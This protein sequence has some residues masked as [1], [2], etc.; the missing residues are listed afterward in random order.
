MRTSLWTSFISSFALMMGSLLT[1]SCSGE[2]AGPG[3][4]IPSDAQ[5][6]PGQ[7]S[8][9]GN[10][11]NSCSDTGLFV[12]EIECAG[13]TVCDATLGCVSCSPGNNL[14][15]G[16]EVHSCNTDGTPGPLVTA[17]DFAQTCRAGACI[18]SC[19][20]AA[21]EFVYLLDSN[22]QLLSFEPRNDTAPNAVKVIGK[23]TCPTTSAPNSMSVDRRARAWLNYDDGK[24]YK[25]PTNNPTACADSG[26]KTGVVPTPKVGMG[27]VSDTAGSK[28]ESL[29][30]ASFG[31]PSQ[32]WKLNPLDAAPIVATR[33]GTFPA[34]PTSPE[35]TGTGAAELYAYFP[36]TDASHRIIRVNKTSGQAELTY[37]LPPLASSPG[38]WA[39]AQW[40][41]RF[42]VFVTESSVSRVYRYDP[43]AAAGTQWIRVQDNLTTRIVGAGVSTCAPTTV[44]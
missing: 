14:C 37:P 22:N 36:A 43:A 42:Y 35:M 23:I 44:G 21:S 32:L 2:G 24:L 15:V 41:G 1:S 7:K 26:Y 10:V 17:C 4:D 6:Q 27:F 19:E 31:S 3:T 5:C 18:D 40:G 28:A 39:F 30:L 9:V 20:L 12:P 29:F 16:T 25:I 34:S 33:V 38:A 13:S 8:C 11:L